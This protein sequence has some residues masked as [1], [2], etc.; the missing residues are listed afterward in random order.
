MVP[1]LRSGALAGALGCL[2][3]A[4]GCLVELER[5][6]SC[7]DGFID[8][9]A[10]EEC[11]P[12]A[13]YD[14]NGCRELGLGSADTKCDPASCTLLLSEFDCHACG[15]GEA[16]G[17]EACDGNDFAPGVECPS[18]AGEIA[19][20]DECVPDLSQCDPC[21]D[22]LKELGE[23]CDPNRTC[24]SDEDCEEGLTCDDSMR[25]VGPFGILPFTPCWTLPLTA[26]GLAAA[27]DAYTDGVVTQENCTDVCKFDRSSCSFCG[28][29]VLDSGY[30]DLGGGGFLTP[31][32]GETCDGDAK[33]QSAYTDFCKD[34]CFDN[35][36]VVSLDVAC[37]AA[38][39]NDGCSGF[40]FDGV[41]EEPDPVDDLGC[42]LK[43]HENCGGNPP[44]PCCFELEHPDEEGCDPVEL[45]C[46]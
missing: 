44:F 26:D 2:V 3:G 43:S 18:G 6:V 5:R 19:C 14:R 38:S 29:G 30:D 27:K 34:A 16:T 37:L 10:G 45:R 15:D 20:T 9:V 4:L 41:P 11:D 35:P 32:P 40:G 23:E 7:G 39:C 12:Q 17:P 21:G 42:C 36:D 13:D 1:T 31:Q 46:R 25:C 8:E 33:N 22:G 24:E 28:D